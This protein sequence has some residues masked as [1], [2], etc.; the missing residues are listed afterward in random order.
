MKIRKKYSITILPFRQV[1][2]LTKRNHWYPNWLQEEAT[3]GC[4]IYDC[5]FREAVDNLKIITK[6]GYYITKRN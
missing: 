2:V 6:D 3:C 5:T 4:T 1:V